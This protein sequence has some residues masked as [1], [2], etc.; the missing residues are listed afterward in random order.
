MSAQLQGGL[1]LQMP[2]QGCQLLPRRYETKDIMLLQDEQPHPDF[3]PTKV[4]LTAT[5]WS[6]H[7][8]CQVYM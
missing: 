2:M 7:G 5:E 1:L 8:V 4:P 3:L 6:E